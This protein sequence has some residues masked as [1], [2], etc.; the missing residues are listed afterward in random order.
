M[1][2]VFEILRLLLNLVIRLVEMLIEW[3]S[4]ASARVGSL[5]TAFYTVPLTPIPGLPLCVSAPIASDYCA[6]WYI[7]EY[8]LFATGTPGALIIPFLSIDAGIWMI[9]YFVRFVL[10]LVRKG[11]RVTSVG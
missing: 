6:I 3:L 5:L 7:L 4:Q 8:T 1:V 2:E 11:E 10:K 9:M